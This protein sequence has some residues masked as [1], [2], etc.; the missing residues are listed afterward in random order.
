MKVKDVPQDHGTIE[1]HGREICYAT[2]E[3]GEY[4]LTHSI[5]WD[6]KNVANDQAWE[7]IFNEIRNIHK[8]I[9]A[10]K[11][12]PLAYHM[13]KNQMTP[14]LLGKYVSISRWRVK[15]HLKPKIFNKLSD[16]I[17]S[18][19]AKI[20]EITIEELK[21]VPKEIDIQSIKYR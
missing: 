19:Y 10:G 8:K 20:L 2:D 4:A 6:V 12:S 17:L 7:I 18:K 21:S 9:I 3:N 14:G 13:T 5:G 16:L 1:D 11:L 15:R